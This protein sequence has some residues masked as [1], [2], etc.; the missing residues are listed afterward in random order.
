MDDRTPTPQSEDVLRKVRDG[1]VGLLR[2]LDLS[3]LMRRLE[4]LD[5]NTAVEK[6]AAWVRAHREPVLLV[7]GGV[8]AAALATGWYLR[9]RERKEDEARN[10]FASGLHAYGRAVQD[11][12][13]MPEE[14]LRFLEEAL[15]AFGALRT[16]FPSARVAADALFYEGNALYEAGRYAEAAE[17]FEE[18]VRRHPRGYLVVFAAENVAACRE[19]EGNLDAAIEAYEAVRKR[20]RRSPFAGRAALAVGRCQELK[21]DFKAAFETY[22]TVQAEAP[23]SFWARQALLRMT[24][25]ET[26]FRKAAGR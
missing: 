4:T 18:Y 15:R 1:V 12:G 8:L 6:A 26:R 11:E 17:R 25:L 16:R 21:G 23:D 9:D 2:R 10:M 3:G 20:W 24:Y 13:L 14:R 5:W 22:Q 19:Q 7:L